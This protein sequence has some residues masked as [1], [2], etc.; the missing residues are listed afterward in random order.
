MHS[1]GTSR[2]TTTN[3]PLSSTFIFYNR[4]QHLHCPARSALGGFCCCSTYLQTCGYRMNTWW[5][6]SS[7]A[8]M[9]RALPLSQMQQFLHGQPQQA[10]ANPLAW[11]IAIGCKKW[12][13]LQFMLQHI[14]WRHSLR[15]HL[16]CGAGL[17]VIWGD[18]I[19]QKMQTTSL[20]SFYLDNLEPSETRTLQK[21]S[22]R[23]LRSQCSTN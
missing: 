22:K 3:S 14:G 16:K 1:L 2:G 5:Q 18:R 12:E 6:G 4:F 10:R 11:C 13:I 20:A 21:S 23:T 15:Y 19:P 17:P 8:L 7:L 9:G